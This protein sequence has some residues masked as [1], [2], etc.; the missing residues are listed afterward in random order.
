MEGKRDRN[1]DKKK[2][3]ISESAYLVVWSSDISWK[4]KKTEMLGRLLIVARFT[5]G[6]KFHL[7]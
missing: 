4:Q 2:K 7:G 1:G 3:D 5:S 6:N